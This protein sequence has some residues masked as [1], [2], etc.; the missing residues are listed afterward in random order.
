[1]TKS[2][3]MGFT[4]SEGAILADRYYRM[5]METYLRFGWNDLAPDTRLRLRY[6]FNLMRLATPQGPLP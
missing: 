3:A 1:M 5:F 4:L 6:R 2:F